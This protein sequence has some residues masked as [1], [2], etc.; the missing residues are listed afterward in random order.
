MGNLTSRQ[1]ETQESTTEKAEYDYLFNFGLLG[2]GGCGK[3]SLI[4]RYVEDYFSG[5][6]IST[7]GV[8]FKIKNLTLKD[9]KIAKLRIWDTAGQVCL[10]ALFCFPQSLDHYCA[11]RTAF[12]LD[13]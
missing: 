11:N 7:I 4:L 3:T 9:G 12:V 5:L 10:R 13:R 6:P 2:D 8:D 1:S